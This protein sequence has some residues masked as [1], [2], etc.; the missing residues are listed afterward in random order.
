MRVNDA[1]IALTGE[2]GEGIIS[3]GDLVTKVLARMGL[4]V[5]TFRTYPA[6]VRG[7]QCIFQVRARSEETLSQG[8]AYDILVCFDDESYKSH[9]QHLR[10]GGVL[11]YNSDTT[12]PQKGDF[13]SYPIALNTVASQKLM[14]P[15]SKNVVVLGAIMGLFNLDRDIVLQLM[16]E[17]WG[18]KGEV[19]EKNVAAL[20]YGAGLVDT[21]IRK[22]DEFVFEDIPRK[23]RIVLSG[24]EAICLGAVAAGM[25]LY[26]GYPI[27][28]ASDILEWFAANL[29]KVGGITIQTE[30]EMAAFGAAMGANFAGVRAMTATSGPGFSLMTELLDLSSMAE[31]PMVL[32]DAQRSGPSTGMPT[33]TEQSDLNQAALGGHGDAPRIVIAPVSVGDCYYQMQKAFNLADKYQ[34]PVVVLSDQSLSHRVEAIP[35]PSP[36]VIE[37]IE[38]LRPTPEQLTH[39]KRYLRTEDGISPMSIPGMSGGSYVATGIERTEEGAPNY[40]PETHSLNMAK[41]WK[42]LERLKA[43]DMEFESYGVPDAKVGIISWGST[44]GVVREAVEKANGMGLK[45]A[46]IHPK[47]V[48]PV[49]ERELTEFIDRIGKVVVV[50]VNYTGQYRRLLQGTL[51]R[52]LETLCKATGLP[53]TTSEVLEKVRG[54]YAHG[55]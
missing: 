23:E 31:V 34:L 27:T 14:N 30:D 37:R 10:H 43:E 42:K 3:L 25:K 49:A 5:F 54:M 2:S 11:I 1:T 29:P 45:V 16:Q 15:R 18:K 6:E 8:D 17:R 7:G 24:N 36:A 19:H 9:H 32:V 28:P 13:V 46:S 26:A 33:K 48:Y 50:E 55:H 4:N 53:F 21:E 41:R 44:V 51:C 12:H 38:P 20:D 47:I 39:F 40:E 35:V 22:V 52:R